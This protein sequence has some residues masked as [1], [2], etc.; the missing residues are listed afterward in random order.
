MLR[1]GQAAE[2]RRYKIQDYPRSSLPIG[3]LRLRGRFAKR[4]SHSAQDD[5]ARA[6][7]LAPALLALTLNDSYGSSPNTPT[8]LVVPTNTLPFAMVG[9]MN[10]LPAP[11]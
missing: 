2:G 1:Y 8:L 10:L 7:T 11:N 3:V 9:V 6:R 5:N 4:S